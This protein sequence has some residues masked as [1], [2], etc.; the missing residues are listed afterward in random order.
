MDPSNAEQM[1]EV[2]FLV[3]QLQIVLGQDNEARKGAEAHL[4]KIKNGEPDKYACYLTAVIIDQNAGNDIK[5]LS[6]VILR[7]SISTNVEG[8]A[9]TLW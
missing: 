7:R 4:N 2:Q 3:G 6:C 9:E 5:A 8:K 1:N